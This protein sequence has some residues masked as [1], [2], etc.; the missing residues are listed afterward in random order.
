M[1]TLL[2]CTNGLN[3]S[4]PVSPTGAP[5]PPICLPG[6][7]HTNRRPSVIQN[8]YRDAYICGT[9]CTPVSI[10]NNGTTRVTRRTGHSRG[11]PSPRPLARY[12]HSCA[13]TYQ[14]LFLPLTMDHITG[15]AQYFLWSSDA[16]HGI[17]CHLPV[18]HLLHQSKTS[19]S[20]L[21]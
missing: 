4:H 14:Y 13:P 1:L 21:A 19:T 15:H 7:T 3:S 18:H 20:M 9:I 10:Q 12:R 16:A 6:Q 2:T 17:R 8:Q 5:S 11:V